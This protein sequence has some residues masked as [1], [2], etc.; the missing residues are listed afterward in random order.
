MRKCEHC[1]VEF[2]PAKRTRR[3]C[4][5]RCSNLG[6]PRGEL[7][8]PLDGTFYE[9]HGDRIRAEKRERYASDPEHRAKVLARVKAAKAYPDK[10][11]CERCGAPRADRHHDDYSKPLDIR[12]LCRACH[13]QHHAEI[14]GTWGSGFT[15]RH[16]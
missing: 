1:G 9:R 5:K 2:K 10:Q 8:Q 14:N 15:A 12:W 6:Q 4:S 3:F 11:P 7:Q 16:A 13:I